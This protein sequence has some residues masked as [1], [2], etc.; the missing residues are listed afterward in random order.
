MM[1]QKTAF[2]KRPN[3]LSWANWD[4]DNLIISWDNDQNI[5]DSHFDHDINALGVWVSIAQPG[6]RF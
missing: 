5:P 1:H 6:V 2:L 3:L 4:D